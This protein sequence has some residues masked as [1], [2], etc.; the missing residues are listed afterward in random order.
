MTSSAVPE[1]KLLRVEL[2]TRRRQRP[3]SERLEAAAAIAFH[4]DSAPALAR[5]ATVA[6][7]LSM[8]SEP[9]T[10][11]LIDALLA[12][13][14]EVIVPLSLPDGSLDWVRWTGDETA[15]RGDLGVPEPH[16]EPLGADALH[17]CEVAI[18]PALAVDHTGHRLGR[19]AGYYDRALVDF[20]GLVCAV[21]FADELR[22][23]IPHESHDVP[24]DFV[25]TP[26]GVFRIP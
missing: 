15:E 17:R 1:K 26:A 13:G 9:G 14:A 4:L 25:L 2:L 5:A 19:G 10:A 16:G 24:V 6:C 18:I 7:H 22:E 3:Q 23:H 21:V 11:A 12:R 8:P 20:P